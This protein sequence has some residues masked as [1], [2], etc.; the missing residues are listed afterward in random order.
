[1]IKILLIT[2]F[3]V[4]LIPLFS[5]TGCTNSD[6]ETGTFQNWTGQTGS[7][8]GINTPTNGLAT[9][10]MN[11]PANIGQHVIMSGNGIDPN[12]CG[13]IPVVAPGSTYSARL[14]NSDSFYGAERLRYTFSITPTNTLIIYK[15]AVVL[16]DAG[17]PAS[18]QPRFEAKLLNQNGQTI[19]CTYYY[20]AAGPGSGFQNCGGIQYKTWT[21]IGVDVTPYIGQT[22]TLDFATGDCGQGAHFG[23]AYVDASCAPFVIDSRY[24]EVQNGLNVAVLSAPAGFQSYQWSNGGTGPITTVVNPQQG[25]VITCQITSVN[26][27]IA[28]LQATLTPSD[29]EASFIPESVCA[30]DTVNLVNTSVFD[31]A[32]QD[33]I[34]WTSS[35]GYT[36]TALNFEHVFS[37][38]G[39]YQIELFVES[40]AGCVDSINQT[41]TVFDIPVAD[42]SSTDACVGQ[43]TLITSS[44]TIADNS[45]LTNLW[46]YNGNTFNG[47]SIPLPT[48]SAD[49]I[50]VQLISTSQ[51]NCS[52]T[53]TESFIIYNNPIADYTYNEVCAGVPMTFN[54][55]STFYASQNSFSWL[56]NNQEVATTADLTYT[57]PSSGNNSVTLIVQDN[58]STV[59]CSDTITQTFLVHGIP[60]I[61]YSGDTTQCEDLPFTFTNNSSNPTGES[62]NYEW[63][64]NNNVVATTP[65][66]TYTINDAGIYPINLSA[67]SSF[68]CENDTIFN[69]YIYPTP[70]EPIL[71]ATTPICPGDPITFNA[72][73]EANSTIS[74]SG[75]QNFEQN[76][77]SFTMP[78]DID[79]MGFYSAFITSQYGCISDTANVLASI[80]YI[81]DFDD[82][83]FPNIITANNDG[84]NDELNLYEYFKTCEE[85][86]LYIYNRWGNKVFEQTLYSP[87]FRGETMTGDM[88]EEGVYFYKLVVRDAEED[89]SV[90][91]GYIHV[92]K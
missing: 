59:S 37:S 35:D 21:T 31:N 18:D 67:T 86:T 52:D 44:S 15:Y 45:A 8:C 10:P 50:S 36:S 54:E 27:C 64:I 92:V 58:Y 71:S 91:H 1:M 83:E 16:E 90:K 78:I 2:F 81:Y 76:S 30:G 32:I 65:N 88:L 62:M 89:K 39:T 82:F 75:P 66:L 55:V 19:P 47:S 20:V 17:H 46:S 70:E 80:L 6:F 13:Q 7:C 41:I 56:Y 84:I 51:N 49:T 23:Y 60:V 87:Q 48:N 22:V 63:L 73:A 77:F 28:N 43:N 11:S 42:I 69:M 74:W 26:G 38:P 40:D 72:E 29:A 85:Y 57:F 79:Q 9:A 53:I 4:N 34:H 25:Q 68:G 24:C 33:S 3:L 5:Q 61:S 14:G 12:S